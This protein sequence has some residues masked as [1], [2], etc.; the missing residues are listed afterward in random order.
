MDEDDLDDDDLPS[1][2]PPVTTAS[3][4]DLQQIFIP[5][6]RHVYS[7]A[8][9]FGD[10]DDD[11]SRSRRGGRASQ[12]FGGLAPRGDRDSRLSNGSVSL[13]IPI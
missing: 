9:D 6:K 11:K 5:K 12:N 3:A 7:V 4:P 10:S 8:V 2:P 13:G 1:L